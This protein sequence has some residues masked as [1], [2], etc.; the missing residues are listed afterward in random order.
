MWKKGW[1]LLITL[2]P[3]LGEIDGDQIKGRK[4]TPF[5]VTTISG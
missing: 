2:V 5:G 1:L 3:E 4:M